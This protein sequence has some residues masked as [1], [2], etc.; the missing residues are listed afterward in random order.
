MFK[1]KCRFKYT[2]TRRSH[3][4]GHTFTYNALCLHPDP[5]PGNE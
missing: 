4:S 1:F 5:A 2:L 3:A